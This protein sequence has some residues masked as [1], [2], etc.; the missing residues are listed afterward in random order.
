MKRDAS[1]VDFYPATVVNNPVLNSTSTNATDAQPSGP[2]SLFDH[3]LYRTISS[4]IFSGQIIASIIVLTFVAIF[5]L[6]EWITQNARPGVF[7]D[8]DGGADPAPDVL[9]LPELPPPQPP[10]HLAPPALPRPPSPPPLVA[11]PAHERAIPIRDDRYAPREDLP[12]QTRTKKPRTRG[13]VHASED[14]Q[15]AGPSRVAKGKRRAHTTA[16]EE[17]RSLRHRRI[18]RR[19]RMFD[20]DESYDE[21]M[22]L[23]DD[24]DFRRLRYVAHRAGDFDD[25]LRRRNGGSSMSEPERWP[26]ERNHKRPRDP[27]RLPAFSEFT[28]TYP[29]PSTTNRDGR[30]PSPPGF[31][32]SFEERGFSDPAPYN[33]FARSQSRLDPDS[34]DDEDEHE[35]TPTRPST[36]ILGSSPTGSYDMIDADEAPAS[37]AQ[38]STS[39]AGLRRPPLPTMTLPPSPIPSVSIE[40]VRGATPLASPSLATYRAPEELDTDADV[41]RDYFV[42]DYDHDLQP[43]QFLDP[44]QVEKEHAHYFREPSDDDTDFD[45]DEDE[46]V[47]AR[48]QQEADARRVRA[49]EMAEMADEELDMDD[50]GEVD[51]DE[52]QW[53]DDDPLHEE[54]DDD[55]GE[56][57][58]GVV[59]IREELPGP[60]AGGEGMGENLP[61]QERRELR[62]I[63][64]QPPEPPLPQDDFDAE[65][66]IE[67]DMDGALEAIGL[68]GPL[69]GVLQNV[70]SVFVYGKVCTNML[71]G[72]AYDFHSGYY[73]RPR[74]LATLHHREVDSALDGEQYAFDIMNSPHY[75]DL[76]QLNPRRAMQLL[77]L[78]LRLIRLVT[79]PVVDSV[80]LLISKLLMP[81]LAHFV[82]VALCSG[83]RLLASALGQDRADKL[84]DLSTDA[85]SWCATSDL[86]ITYPRLC[87]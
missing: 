2:P 13:D 3:P 51:V 63:L 33:P 72:R 53:T 56:G 20:G 75:F 81:P 7:E 9:P 60:F 15:E 17:R 64:G 44:E 82:Q 27:N 12:F 4:D 37:S 67:D 6:R 23:H 39:A 79:D 43:D 19:T 38:P 25:E 85:V 41:D 8:G 58:Q 22:G 32:S 61:A 28:F 1:D 26:P 57:G 29:S 35:R 77:H 49:Q 76:F 84:A 73:D 69:V 78:P 62:I 68:R 46:D 86:L 52:L 65:V 80:L 5:L 14:S 10:V 34:D 50:E 48:F 66:N 30:S 21:S 18:G 74:N 31:V 45:T 24:K 36:P 87:L 42:H 11:E 71:P 54:D 55:E 16:R 47:R 40:A 83:L 70:G 59:Q